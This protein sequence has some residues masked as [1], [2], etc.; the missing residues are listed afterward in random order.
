[1][2]GHHPHASQSARTRSPQP[3][4]SGVRFFSEQRPYATR[5]PIPGRLGGSGMRNG[6]DGSFAAPRAPWRERP[7]FLL[8]RLPEKIHRESF[9]ICGSAGN[10]RRV[11]LTPHN[12]CRCDYLHLPDASA[13]P[14]GGARLLPDLRHGARAG[15]AHGDR[16][17]FRAGCGQ[18]QVL[19]R[20]R[21][22]RTRGRDGDAAA[23]ARSAFFALDGADAAVPGVAAH[24]AGGALGRIRLLPPR[25]ARGTEPLAEHVHA[26]RAR[27]AG[28]LLLQSVR[29]FRARFFSAGNARRARHGGRLFRG[30]RRHHRA[31]VAGRM[32]RAGRAWPHQR[33]IRQLLGLAP[34]TARRIRTDG[35]EEDVPLD[36]LVDRRSRARASGRK[37]AG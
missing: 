20:D 37:G 32:A 15:N 13:D 28:R 7:L 35:A 8:R 3:S 9:A 18:A 16:R 36:Q 24:A 25:L 33:A 2:R 30:G 6:S 11:A 21:P 10:A 27:R 23:S 5:A 19:D 34:K 1:M 29:D 12:R 17:Q 26:D 14:P 31:R 4:S 22:Q